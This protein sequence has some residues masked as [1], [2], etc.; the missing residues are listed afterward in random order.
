MPDDGRE[1]AGVNRR[2]YLKVLGL[3]GAVGLAGCAGGGGSGGSSGSTDT[4]SGGDSSDGGSGEST[5]G[6]TDTETSE[7][8]G[9]GGS[10]T[11]TVG[12]LSPF[13]GGLGWIGPNSRRGIQTALEGEGGVNTA[14]VLESS[15]EITEQD[16]ET[17]PQPAISGFKT[18]DSQDVPAM[19][20]PSSTVT[21]SLVEPAQS[22]GLA[23]VSPMTGTIQLDDV[24]GEYVW[25]TVPSD[26]IGARCQAQYAYQEEGHRKMALAYK[27]DKGSQSFSKASGEYFQNLG[28]EVLTEVAL[29]PTSSSYR[30][31]VQKLQ[32]SGAEVVS[33]TAGTEVSAL[34]FKNY[35]EAGANEDFQLLLG[36]DVLT[37]DFIEEVGPDVIEGAVG[38]APAPGP[39]YEQF[40][41]QHQSMHDKEPGA[42][43]AAAYDAMNLIALAFVKEG[44]AN[45]QAVPNHLSDL[46]NP[47]GEKVSTFAAGKEVLANGGEID[48]QGASNPQNFDDTG[49]PLGP[50]AALK[51]Q[52]GEW[53]EVITYSADELAE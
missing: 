20:G 4:S 10:N 33:M 51:A 13:S 43:S 29:D 46:G 32:D 22:S 45:R 1:T 52:D 7:N 39:S 40:A 34:F 41:E 42:F 8:S 30:S 11:I 3:A 37:P 35:V 47:P 53:S 36:N 24:G 26:S 27:N 31:E 38:Q 12:N 18:L 14:G 21:P 23:F 6:S 48:Y 19:V 9:G 49:D 2:R 44:E 17:K 15:I 5:S 50:F 16:T 25:R 28:G